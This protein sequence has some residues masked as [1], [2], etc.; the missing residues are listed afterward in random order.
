VH[1]HHAERDE[2]I[3]IG[4]GRVRYRCRL[5]VFQLSLIIVNFPINHLCVVNCHW[6]CQAASLT[7]AVTVTV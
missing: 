1:N 2:Y 4:N 3:F 7:L 5:G 6:F